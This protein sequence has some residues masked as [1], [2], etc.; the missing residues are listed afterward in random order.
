MSGLPLLQVQ[1]GQQQL[2]LLRP[3][4][5]PKAQEGPQGRLQIDLGLRQA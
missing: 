2:S 4:T 1:L 5:F 3:W